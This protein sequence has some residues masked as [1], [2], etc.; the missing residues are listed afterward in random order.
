MAGAMEYLTIILIGIPFT[1]AYNMEATMLQAVGNSMTPLLFLLF[2]G[3]LNI[4]LDYAFMA[5]LAMG[6]GGAAFATVFI[7]GGKCISGIHTY[8]AQLSTASF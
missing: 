7:T 2:S 8:L 1:M 6:I 4:S 5:P 3:V